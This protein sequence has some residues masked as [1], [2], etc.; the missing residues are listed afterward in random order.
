M[1]VA[2]IILGFLICT[3]VGFLGMYLVPKMFK[4]LPP[5]NDTWIGPMLFAFVA[6][7]IATGIFSDP[8]FERLFTAIGYLIPLFVGSYIATTIKRDGHFDKVFTYPEMNHALMANGCFGVLLSINEI[9][10]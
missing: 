9:L 10:K 7:L 8:S 3:G 5:A 6:Q 1:L 4:S 2:L